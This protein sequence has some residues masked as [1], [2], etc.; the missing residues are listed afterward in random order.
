MRIRKRWLFAVALALNCLVPA[1]AFC[2]DDADEPGG[3]RPAFRAPFVQ[4]VTGWSAQ[5]SAS[6]AAPAPLA[7]PAVSPMPASPPAPAALSSPTTPPSSAEA[8]SPMA[9]TSN[10]F[11]SCGGG[12]CCGSSGCSV[13][14]MVESTF[15][16]PQLHRG[17]VST[18]FTN[19]LGPNDL[20]ASSQFGSANGSFLVAPRITLGLQGE[21][22]GVV[23]RYWNA[24]TW[25]SAFAPIP[26]LTGGSPLTGVTA[27]DGFRAYTLDLELQ[28]RF[29]LGCWN[30]YGFGGI[31]YASVGNARN[32][33]SVNAFDGDILNSSSYASQTFNG[34]GLTFG[35]WGISPLWDCSPFSLFFVNRYSLLWGTGRA[36]TQTNASV[37]TP[38]AFAENANGSSDSSTSGDMFIGEIQVGIQ[39]SAQLRCLPAP[40]CAFVRS[41]FEY[42]YWNNSSGLSVNSAS[43]A[44]VGPQTASASAN[45][46]D[47]LFSLV[48]FNIGAGIMY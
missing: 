4:P 44:F 34:T 27:F 48:G 10:P 40:A 9:D 23:G 12:P 7:P 29:C 14:A 18:S 32:L 11:V 24:N 28:R 43:T 2:D 6:T 16:W 5:E 19:S 15:F 33:N 31:R 36:T 26:P 1:H 37:A 35:L 45:S 8:V 21:C 25:G 42:Q 3:S 46:G 39:W 38:G 30:M 47:F 17:V 41:G 20:I 13:I 22:W